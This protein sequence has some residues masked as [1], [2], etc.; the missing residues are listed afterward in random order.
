MNGSDPVPQKISRETTYFEDFH[1]SC[2]IEFGVQCKVVNVGDK[3]CNLLLEEMELFFNLVQGAFIV[4]VVNA[5]VVVVRP[6]I[7]IVTMSFLRLSIVGSTAR[8]AVRM[9]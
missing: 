1:E 2:D 8:R 9:A 6:P 5:F 7:C 4:A 3:V